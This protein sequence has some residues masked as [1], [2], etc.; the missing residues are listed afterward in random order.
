MSCS[1][2]WVV[3]IGE[4]AVSP[5]RAGDPQGDEE[6]AAAAPGACM[7]LVVVVLGLA[8]LPLPRCTAR[9][10]IAQHNTIS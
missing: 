7:K 4:G 3:G 1:G 10:D 9:H 8:A 5:E 2:A 6:A